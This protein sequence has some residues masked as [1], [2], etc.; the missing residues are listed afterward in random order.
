M[1]QAKTRTH[2]H[3]LSTFPPSQFLPT[4]ALVVFTGIVYMLDRW[5]LMAFYLPGTYLSWVYL[6]FFQLQPH[7]TGTYGDSLDKFKV[8]AIILCI[9]CC[10]PF[11]SPY[12]ILKMSACSMAFS[13]SLSFL[14]SLLFSSPRSSLTSWPRPSTGWQ[15]LAAW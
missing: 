8:R 9:H 2:S 12:Q 5:D 14:P 15:P 1:T 7:T 3:T 4:V 6:R 11:E 10:I 13:F